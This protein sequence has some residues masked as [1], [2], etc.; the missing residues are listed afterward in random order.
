MIY[1]PM[2]RR[3]IAVLPAVLA[4]AGAGVLSASVADAEPA[5]P[6]CSYTLS[7]P[8]VVQVSGADRVTAT[9]TPAGCT[10]PSSPYLSVA[11]LQLQGSELAPQ[12]QHTLGPRTAQV[13][14]A[15]HRPGATYVS[16]GKGC[17]S[18]GNPQA[19][20]CE[21]LGPLTATP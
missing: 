18:T 19:S 13:Y 5:P 7:S 1:D 3:R 2:M 6:P 21:S 15:P 20:F 4:L 8:Q 11:C 14:Y 12:C 10:A 9:M 17:A 16:T